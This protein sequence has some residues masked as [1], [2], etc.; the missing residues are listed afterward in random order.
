LK[1]ATWNING[2]KA[3]LENL[4]AWLEDARP[5]LACLQETKTTD[6]TFP[7]EPVEALGYAVET[8]GE[9]GFNGVALLSRLPLEDV[10]RGLPGDGADGQ[11]RFIEGTAG[12]VRVMCGY[13]PNG[14]PVGSEKLGYKFSWLAR[15]ERHAA[16]RLRLEEKLVI[17]GDFNIIPEPRDVRHPERWLDDALF[18]PE[19]R[20]A[21]R[22][23]LAAGLTDAVRAVS[24]AERVYSFWDY[25]GGSWPKDDGIRIDHLL[26]S[27]E[28]ADRLAA[29]GIDRHVRAWERPSD[30]V[31]VWIE[32]SDA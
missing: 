17:A 21:Y 10:T 24:D 27:P 20:A 19:S 30:H 4:L 26:L 8:H 22:R 1:I 31:P 2:V 25:Q 9:K 11:A 28:A 3:R 13:M 7:R 14:N 15:L 32:L 23:L 5:D 16:D 12:G 6:D 18:L 29:V